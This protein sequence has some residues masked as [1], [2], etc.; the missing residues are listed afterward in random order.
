M[1]Y[2]FTI[3]LQNEIKYQLVYYLYTRGDG[4]HYLILD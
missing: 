2:N 4:G 3:I 1:T